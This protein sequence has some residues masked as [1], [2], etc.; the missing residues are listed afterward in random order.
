MKNVCKFLK[1][2]GTYYLATT[3]GDRPRVRPFGTAHI[4]EEKLYIQTGKG[5]AVARQIA[6]NPR[7]E[8]CA[9]RGDEW[10][11]LEGTLVPD[12]RTEAQESMLDN[13]PSLRKM[14]TTGPEGNTAVYY[15]RDATA[16][17]YSFSHEPVVTSF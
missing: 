4:F 15:F 6:A 3:D 2:A 17:V 7:V 14:Y 5:K 8:I 9:M 11:R 1:E 16:T 10:L 13:Y 12:D